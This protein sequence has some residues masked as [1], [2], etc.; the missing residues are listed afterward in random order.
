VEPWRLLQEAGGKGGETGMDALD[1][2]AASY[3]VKDEG[4][5]ARASYGFSKALLASYTYLLSRQHHPDLVI[6][7][8]SPGLIKT[9]MSDAMSLNATKRPEDGAVPILHCLLSD[10]VVT[11]Y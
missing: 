7:S 2:L 5:D 8:V 4:P 11:R 3:R 9:D 1:K 6:N 10:K